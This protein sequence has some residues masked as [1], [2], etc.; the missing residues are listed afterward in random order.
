M[1]DIIHLRRFQIICRIACLVG[2]P[3][4]KQ[5]RVKMCTCYFPFCTSKCVLFDSAEGN[6]SKRTCCLTKSEPRAEQTH[7]FCVVRWLTL[8]SEWFYWEMLCFAIAVRTNQGL[9]TCALA[10]GMH[11][12]TSNKLLAPLMSSS[13]PAAAISFGVAVA[14]HRQLLETWREIALPPGD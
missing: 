3:H 5:E 8:S 12:I 2:P 13:S 6:K 1:F 4:S 7:H 10:W 9:D 11:L 14:I